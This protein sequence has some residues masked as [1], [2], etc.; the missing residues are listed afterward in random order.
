MKSRILQNP[1]LGEASFRP[2]IDE[3]SES[4][5]KITLMLGLV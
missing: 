1:S 3:F 4:R 2:T 5:R